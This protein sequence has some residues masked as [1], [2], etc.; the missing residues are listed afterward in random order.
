MANDAER[1]YEIVL[2]HFE[3]GVLSGA[4]ATDTNLPPERDLATKLGVGRAA[5]R[6]A[7]RVLQAQ[8]L[9]VPAVGRGG[10]TRITP[11]QP[12]A[13]ARIFRL[14]LA[15][16][17]AG[18]TE[19]TET[20]VAL[21]RA[22]S[23]TA[24]VAA[25]PEHLAGLRRIV[26]GMVSAGEVD[27]FSELDTA[28]HVAIARC[29]HSTLLTDLTVAVRQTLEEPIRAAEKRLA[30]WGGFHARL[31]AEHTAILTAIVQRDPERAALAMET[32]IRGAY[33]V[34]AEA[35]VLDTSR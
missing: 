11:A 5:V 15:L 18:L 26:A 1:A 24:A 31:V 23:S 28:F 7:M 12:D 9:I 8:G 10:G 17:G 22:T 27:T 6:E 2:R 35:E 29:G 33:A 34:L 32:H 4:Y 3:E 14:H 19:L 16:S 30:D 20:R 21:E 25:T 13:L